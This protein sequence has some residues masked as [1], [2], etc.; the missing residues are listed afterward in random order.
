MTNKNQTKCYEIYVSY[1][2]WGGIWSWNKLIFYTN[3]HYKLILYPLGVP[4]EIPQN[5]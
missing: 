5:F 2:F 3:P 4:S 1:I